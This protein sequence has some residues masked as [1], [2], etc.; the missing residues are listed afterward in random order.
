MKRVL[1]VDDEPI[2]LEASCAL[3]SLHRYEVRAAESGERA[4]DIASDF[5]PDILVVDRM[6]GGSLDG[7]EVAET[8]LKDNSQL[9][10]LVVTGYAS[11]DLACWVEKGCR[12][13]C[14][15]K[16][17]APDLLIEAVRTLATSEN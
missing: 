6:L 7:I 16:P 12:V 13:M 4:L 14:L 5:S 3:L 17:V 10:V 15:T 8:L 11:E 1:V 2:C 9:A